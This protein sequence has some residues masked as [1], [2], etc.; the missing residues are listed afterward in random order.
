VAVGVPAK[1]IGEVTDE[2]R[3]TWT[4]FKDIYV[5]LASRRYPEEL[6]RA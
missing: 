3:E 1:V 5:D 2:Y 6:R 4:R